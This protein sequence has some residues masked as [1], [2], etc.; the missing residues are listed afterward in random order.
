GNFGGFAL[1][2]T[3]T[4]SAGGRRNGRRPMSDT[5]IVG[6]N[7]EIIETRGTR[8]AFTWSVVIAGALAAWAVFFIFVTLG[9][10]IGLS[11]ASPFGG[12]SAATL[13]IAGAI[14]LIF[15]ET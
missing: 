5:A 11:V 14:W 7:V 3:P 4:D 15:S 6:E 12:P 10:G 13:G 1:L 8:S 9:S 2:A